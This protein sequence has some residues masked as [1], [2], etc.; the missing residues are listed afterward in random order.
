[1]SKRRVKKID[2]F[3]TS[4]I[5][6]IIFFFVSLVMIIPMMLIMGVAGGYSRMPGLAFGSLLMIFMPIIY[7]VMSFIMTAIWCWIYNLVAK[8]IGGIEIEIEV[9]DE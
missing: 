1:M 6:A 5:S 2:V 7:A 8:Q 4:L 9:V 3:K